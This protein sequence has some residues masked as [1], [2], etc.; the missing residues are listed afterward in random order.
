MADAVPSRGRTIALVVSLSLNLL[1]VGLIAVVLSRAA[2]GALAVAQPGGQLAP[3]LIARGLPP[4]AQDKIR[5]VQA[6]HRDAMMEARRGARQARQ[7][8]LRAFA[9]PDYAPG[10]FSD[11]LERVR[12]ADGKL[13]EEAILMLRDTVNGLTPDERKTVV[14]RMRSGANRLPWW[15]RLMNRAALRQQQQAQ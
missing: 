7:A 4:E 1:L 13:E 9:A 11:A 8:A 12:A 10:A 5:G 6:E 3:A 15:R 14:A 2:G